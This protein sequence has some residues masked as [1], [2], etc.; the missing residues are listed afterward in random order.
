MKTCFFALLTLVCSAFSV[1]ANDTIKMPPHPR[2]LLNSNDVLHLKERVKHPD[3]KNIKIVF[4][5]QLAYP[6]DGQST[7][8]VPDEKIRQKIEAL[9]LMYLIDSTQNKSSGIKAI[10]L[11]EKYLPSIQKVK[12]Y[13]ENL[14]CYEAVFGAAMV[15][16]WCYKLLDSEDKKVLISQMKR[17][18]C[19]G[20]YCLERGT[21]KQ[22]LSGHY[23]EVGANV[24]LAQGI[25]TYDE[26]KEYFDF[27]YAEQVNYFAKSRNPMFESGTHHQGSQYIAVRYYSEILQAFMLEKLG[28]NPYSKKIST[29]AYRGI[30]QTIPQTNDMD[31]MAEGD[32][33]NKLGMGYFPYANLAAQLSEDPYLQSYSK[34]YL[35]Q[36]ENYSARAFIFHNPK[37]DAK[38]IDKLP[39]SRFFSSPS[40]LMFARTNWDFNRKDY[41]SNAMVVLMNMREYSAKNHQHLDLGHFSI[42]Y[43]G[44]LAL[45]SGI[46]QGGEF[47]NEWGKLNYVN[48]YTRTVA[49]NSILIYDP[50]EPYPFEGSDKRAVS[51]DG[52]QFSLNNRAW[53]TSKEMFDAGKSAE[54]L[55][56]DIAKG[57]KPTYSYL[58][59]DMTR[60]YNCPPNVEIYPAKADTVRRSFVFL[61]LKS[62]KIPGVLMVFDKVV[63]TNASFKKSWLL[64]SQNEP[65]ILQSA[66][67]FENTNQG[68]NGKLHNDILLPE[69]ENQEIEK[70]GGAGKEYWV[71][72]KNYGKATQEDAGRWRIEL[73]PKNASKSD[74]FLN[75]IQVMDATSKITPH[76]VTKKRATKGD[77]IAV[78]VADCIVVQHLALD[79]YNDS[80]HFEIGKKTKKYKVLI[81]DLQA[82]TWKVKSPSGSFR[83]QVQDGSGTLYF[84][85]KGGSFQLVPEIPQKIIVNKNQ[86]IIIRNPLSIDRNN[87]IIAIACEKYKNAAKDL[88]PQIKCKSTVLNS[89]LSDGNKDGIWDELLVEVNLKASKTDTLQLN[90]IKKERVISPQQSTNI[91]F[92]YKSKST[93]PNAEIDNVSR[94]RGFT[95]N[96]TNPSFQLE[97]P[98]IENDKVAF[99]H[100]FDKRNSKDVFGKL[101]NEMVLE[102]VGLKGSW[103]NLQDWGMDILQTGGSIGAGGFGI[104]ENN[105]IYSLAD[106]DNSIFNH[107]EEGALKATYSIQFKNWDCG[108]LKKDGYELVSIYKG[109]FFYTEKIKVRLEKDQKLIC[110]MPN[111]TSD[112]LYVKVHNSKFSSIATFDKQAQ[113]TSSLLGLAIMFPTKNFVAKGKVNT[114]NEFIRSNFV[115]LDA[116]ENDIQTIRFFACWEKTDPRFS[117]KIGF[118]TYLQDTADKLANPI[119]VFILDKTT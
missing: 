111:F 34:L 9:A 23:G 104:I 75:V 11:V 14:H 33:H 81:T 118:D 6:T 55:A 117:S 48:Y 112:S 76:V 49:H 79:K 91:R 32:C 95:Q 68:R 87:E 24:F 88:V 37:I 42:Y 47:E 116:T 70:I 106:A 25:A 18:S 35:S 1:F 119:Q 27:E 17:V 90:W 54:I 15:Y 46:Y 115:A 102:K 62:N 96:S 51:R 44:H 4:D 61:N 101:T 113:G 41:K 30:Y 43:K 31:G 108:R 74:N 92:S 78:E 98:G 5:K 53:N 99:R 105:T 29:L 72:G 110:G 83:S 85:S 26:D 13:H 103:H 2:L 71:D 65:R 109:D 21:P 56:V 3:F 28:L 77:H 64:H 80:I 19:L 82:G 10:Q 100:F 22:Y 39:L 57:P 73:S 58:K 40:G 7:D 67:E 12:G 89:Q 93:E 86:D 38:P 84:E 45:D 8:G 52:G 107:I 66:V 20:E 60:A 36:S 114:A 59:G 94:L 16:D 69:P 97:G 63:S 50:N